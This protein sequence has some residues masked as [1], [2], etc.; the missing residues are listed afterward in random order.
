ML[1]ATLR[2]EKAGQ[3]NIIPDSNQVLRMQV[4]GTIRIR[5]FETVTIAANKYEF[6]L[7]LMLGLVS[8]CWLSNLLYLPQI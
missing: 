8:S 4:L 7:K 5:S 2:K 6:I 3:L 1:S